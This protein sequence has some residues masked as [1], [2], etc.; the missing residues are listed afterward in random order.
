MKISLNWLSDYINIPVSPEEL[1]DILTDLGLEV[2]GM[3]KIEGVPGGLAGVK[4]GH[5]VECGKHPNADRLSLTKVDLGVGEPVQIVCGAPNVAQGQKVLVATV[6]TKLFPHGGE[7]FKIKKGKIRGEVSEGMICAEDELGIGT[8]H[9]GIM[10]LAED[11]VIG[12]DAKDHL[13]L[14]E[15]VIYDIGLTPN[16]SDAT[17]HIGVARDLLAYFKVH[18]LAHT[19]IKLPD[20][21][22]FSMEKRDFNHVTVDIKDLV[23]CPRYSAVSLSE[24]NVKESPEW[25]K[26]RLTA[27]GVRTI[28]NI[29]DITNFV[30]HETGQ[31]LHAFDLQKI[32]GEKVIVQNLPAGTKF[33]TLDEKERTLAEDDLMICNGNNEGMCIAGIFG[34]ITSGVTE[35]TKHIFLESAHFNAKRI[36]VSSTRH[37]LRTDAAM[38]FEKGTDPNETIFALKRAAQLMESEA[39]AIISSDIIDVYPEEIK[40]AAIHVTYKKV[41]DLIGIELSRETISRILDAL[42]IEIISTTED[43]FTVQVPTNKADVTRDVDII[44]EILRVYGFNN[45]PFSSKMTTSIS[46]TKHPDPIAIQESLSD[47]LVSKGFSEMMNLSLSQSEKYKKVLPEYEDKFVYI[48]NTSNIHLDIMRPEMMLPALQTLQYNKNRQVKDIKYFEF[49]RSYQGGTDRKE[50]KHLI[51]I[52]SGQLDKQSWHSENRDTDFYDMRRVVDEII[53][54]TGANSYKVSEIQNNT[55]WEYGLSYERGKDHIVSFGSIKKDVLRLSDVADDVFYAEFDLNM[56]YKLSS[57]SKTKI[58][59]ISKFPTIRRDLAMVIDNSSTFSEI[60]GIIIKSDKKLIKEVNL[61]DVY[62]NEEQLGA[63]KKSYAVSIVF[64]DDSKTLQDKD[65]DPIIKKVTKVLEEK[66][67]AS[68]R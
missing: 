55:K 23:G 43:S 22:N 38:R 40:P 61:F 67:G 8:D 51:L 34:G 9:D 12:Q 10:V 24:V 7:P 28:N 48:N 33:T 15:D 32:A 26:K 16:R 66:L 52:L 41:N 59:P 46:F 17:S 42:E 3:D 45:V 57:Q 49:G 39:D 27:I 56:L 31:P 35:T 4:V 2:E 36:R 54:K 47:L 6:G 50:D 13:K 5:V 18:N 62:K 68:L 19:G 30:L 63:G 65:I 25:I 29:V 14:E 53:S 44:E 11:A 58:K 60:E 37:L 64:E 21:Y 20:T 1:S